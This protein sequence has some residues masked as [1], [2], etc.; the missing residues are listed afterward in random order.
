[1]K[2]LNNNRHARK[3]HYK[4]KLRYELL[5]GYKVDYLEQKKL[6]RK[7]K[8]LLYRK[9]VNKNIFHVNPLGIKTFRMP[10]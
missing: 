2:I 4:R 5:N 9:M 1:M 7:T 10:F 6:L 8:N 3:R